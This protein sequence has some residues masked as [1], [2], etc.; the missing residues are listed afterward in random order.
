VLWCE[1]KDMDVVLTVLVL[2]CDGTTDLALHV[3]REQQ[4]VPTGSKGGWSDR[5]RHVWLLVTGV[6]E[7]GISLS[8]IVPIARGPVATLVTKFSDLGC[9]LR[10]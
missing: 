10:A 3:V 4:M 7:R 5:R 9:V 6:V 2:P 1:P 8:D